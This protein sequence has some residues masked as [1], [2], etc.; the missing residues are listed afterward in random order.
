MAAELKK[1]RAVLARRNLTGLANDTKWKELVEAFLAMDYT[2]RYQCKRID[3]EHVFKPCSEWEAIPWPATSIEWL[4]VFFV[5]RRR[6]GELLSMHSVDHS[7]EVEKV[8]LSVGLDFK[9]GKEC[10]RVFGYA[11]RDEHGFDGQ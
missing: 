1:L 4:D 5:E 7:S 3:G 10:F 11:P 6:Q 2:P 8:L 9:K